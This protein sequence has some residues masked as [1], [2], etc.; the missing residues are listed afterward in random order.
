MTL[1]IILAVAVSFGAGVISTILL[2]ARRNE[3]ATT[4]KIKESERAA[5]AGGHTQAETL[6]T[7]AQPVS[8]AGPT[9]GTVLS[10]PLTVQRNIVAAALGGIFVL[11]MVALYASIEPPEPTTAQSSA[12]SEGALAIERLAALTQHPETE[13]SAPQGGLASVEDMIDRLAARLKQ[14]PNDPEGWRMLGWSYFSTQRFA[15]SAAAY[16]KAIELRPDFAEFRSLRGEALVSAANGMITAEATRVF[17]EALAR[18]P[19]DSRARFFK[20]LAKAQSGDKV[21]A[22][23]D[24]MA[25]LKGADPNESWHAEIKQRAVAL[26]R[27][28]G[29]DVSARLGGHQTAASGDILKALGGDPPPATSSR[30]VHPGPTAGDVRAASTMP[31]SDRVA[32]IRGMVDGLAARLEQSP[33]DAEGWIKLMRSRVVLGEPDQAKQALERALAIFADAPQERGQI[34]AAAQELGVMR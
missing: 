28:I 8:G 30:A 12:R 4:D 6:G 27:E 19:A 9:E 16:L 15:E 31:A 34:V 10:G 25:I 5:A 22:L 3:L 20:G 13:Q 32:M 21:S 11:A 7:S 1:W 23:N 33:R 29:V 14:H 26:G 24:W 2:S 17:D 18:D